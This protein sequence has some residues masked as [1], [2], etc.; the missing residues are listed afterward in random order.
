MTPTQKLKR[1]I[2]LKCRSWSGDAASGEFVPITDE[3]VEALYNAAGDDFPN[4]FY[5]AR[6]EIRG[7]GE[8]SGI[9]KP[10]YS[11]HYESDEVALRCC[12]ETWIGW[13]Y[14]HGGGKHGEPSAVPWMEEAYDVVCTV[15]TRPVNIFSLPKKD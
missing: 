7:G 5:D 4:C 15:E 6:E 13:T 8:R 10:N 9:S 3:N 14:W 11:R 2:I 1:E 12:D